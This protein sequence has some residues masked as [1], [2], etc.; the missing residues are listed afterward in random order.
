[1]TIFVPGT[2]TKQ[3]LTNAPTV[4]FVRGSTTSADNVDELTVGF[5]QDG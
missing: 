5:I 3:F 4:Q 1:M 2:S